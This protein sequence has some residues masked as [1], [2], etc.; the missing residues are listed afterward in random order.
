MS[1]LDEVG[2]VHGHLLDLSTVELF[3]LAHHANIVLGNEVDGNTLSS[4]ATTTAD[5]MNVVL[6]VG[7]QI[8]V[9]DQRDLLN[10]DTTSKEVSGDEDAGRT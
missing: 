3:D 10:I 7:G 9:D 6:T 5:A 4:E 8:V 2:N 1:C